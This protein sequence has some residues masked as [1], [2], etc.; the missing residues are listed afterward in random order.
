[1]ERYATVANFVPSVIHQFLNNPKYANMSLPKVTIMTSG[2][3]HLPQ[4]L[5]AKIM[6]RAPNLRLF[7][8]GT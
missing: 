7:Q 3:A 1:M 5:R 8:E 6:K 4:E 2:A